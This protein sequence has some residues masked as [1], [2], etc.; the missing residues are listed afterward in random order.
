MNRLRV[1][2][3]AALAA[4]ASVMASSFHGLELGFASVVAGSLAG[5]ATYIGT[6]S[7]EKGYPLNRVT[8][9]SLG[10]LALL[11]AGLPSDSGRRRQ[12]PTGG[13]SQVR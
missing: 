9:V 8:H 11:Q 7:G 12:L 1:A 3:L 2:L 6:P 13:G 10:C 5:F 4:A